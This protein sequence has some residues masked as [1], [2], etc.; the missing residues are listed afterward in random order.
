MYVPDN[1]YIY[2]KLNNINYPHLR[3]RLCTIPGETIAGYIDYVTVCP[4]MH[5]PGCTA[6]VDLTL[7]TICL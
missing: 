7:D 6:T 3:R 4:T 2:S 1:L 5:V